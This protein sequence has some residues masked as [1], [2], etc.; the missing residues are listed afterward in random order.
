M[1]YKHYHEQEIYNNNNIII[2]SRAYFLHIAYA[3]QITT[4]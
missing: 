1:E 2:A 4:I 3:E